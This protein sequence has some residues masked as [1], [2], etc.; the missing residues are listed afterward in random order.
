MVANVHGTT[1]DVV[2]GN[3]EEQ[4]QSQGDNSK[5]VTSQKNNMDRS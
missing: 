3:G 1:G 2:S 5:N 4:S